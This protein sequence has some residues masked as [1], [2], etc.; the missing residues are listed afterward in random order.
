M[1]SR[2]ANNDKA[3]YIVEFD[4]KPKNSGRGRP[5]HVT[6]RVESQEAARFLVVKLQKAFELKNIVFRGP[7]V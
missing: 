3:R 5:A 2:I 6:H 7:G 1:G 4:S